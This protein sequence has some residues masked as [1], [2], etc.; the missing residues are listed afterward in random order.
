MRNI[1]KEVWLYEICPVE[2]LGGDLPD[3]RDKRKDFGI[4]IEHI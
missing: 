4:C 3:L 2:Y 1:V